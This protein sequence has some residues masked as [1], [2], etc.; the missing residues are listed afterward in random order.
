M[1]KI[2]IMA[3]ALFALALVSPVW[4]ATKAATR[5]QK[6]EVKREK[7]ATNATT[8]LTKALNL[9]SAQ[10]AKVQQVY[11]D[12]NSKMAALYQDVIAKRKAIREDAEKQIEATLNPDQLQKY[13]S[14]KAGIRA[15]APKR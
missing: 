1:K 5:A 9:S 10:K 6:L 3:A 14:L 7:W 13:N 11:A 15:R 8:R 4:A 2:S 12:H